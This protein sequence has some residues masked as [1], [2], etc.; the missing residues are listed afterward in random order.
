MAHHAGADLA[1]RRARL[2]RALAPH[3]ARPLAAHA[4]VRGGGGVVAAGS[5][6]LARS[7]GR[8][9]VVDEVDHTS[10]HAGRLR[11]ARGQLKRPV[12]LRGRGPALLM[13]LLLL[14]LRLRRRIGA[15]RRRPHQRTVEVLQQ[16]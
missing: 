13:L 3:G 15:R 7:G 1:L 6:A 2:E 12:L 11:S 10:G 16:L 8:R 4:G 9:A 5:L 14:L